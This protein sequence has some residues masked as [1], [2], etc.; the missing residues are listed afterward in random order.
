MLVGILPGDTRGVGQRV[1]P[2]CRVVLDAQQV[3]VVHHAR[4]RG[5]AAVVGAPAP[6]LGDGAAHAVGQVVQGATARQHAR[7]DGLQE[8]AIH[9][10]VLRLLVVE[11]IEHRAADGAEVFLLARQRALNLEEVGGR[12]VRIV[13]IRHV[14]RQFHLRC[15]LV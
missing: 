8:R 10:G 12:Q 13:G 2:L 15:A 5:G 14:P 4:G 1:F 6:V 11:G 3:Q 7:L 9:V